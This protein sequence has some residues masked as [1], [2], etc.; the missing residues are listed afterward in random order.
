MTATFGENPWDVDDDL[1]EKEKR[2][3]RSNA[4]GEVD[5]AVTD[6]NGFFGDQ[7][8]GF[9]ADVK[10]GR[11]LATN[12]LFLK[13]VNDGENVP[14]RG[15]EREAMRNHVSFQFFNGLGAESEESFNA[16]IVKRTTEIND[17]R[18][19]YK[20]LQQ[21]AWKSAV[22]SEADPDKPNPF[23]WE[24]FHEKAKSMPGYKPDDVVDLRIAWNES[25]QELRQRVEPFREELSQ[26]WGAMKQGGKGTLSEILKEGIG[27]DL[28]NP[29]ET[30][31]RAGVE[32]KKEDT[33]ATAY[34]IYSGLSDD[35][36]PMFL[37]AL[38]VVAQTFP[39]EE[40]EG[41]FNN[42]V[43]QGGRG[44]DDFADNAGSI[45]GRGDDVSTL[46]D[47][48]GGVGPTGAQL[49]R[50]IQAERAEILKKKDFVDEVKRIERGDFSPVKYLSDEDSGFR[51]IEEGLYQAP[52]AFFTS[53]VFATPMIGQALALSSIEGSSYSVIRDNLL[54]SGVDPER[55][56]ILAGD[57][58]PL[59]AIPQGIMEKF[60]ANAIVGKMPFF[61]AAM[62]R[63]GDQVSNLAVRGAVR[64]GVGAGQEALLEV[65]QD[66]VNFAVQDIAS[67]LSMDV[68]DVVWMDG[69]NGVLDGFW[70]D[71]ATNFVTMLPLAIFGAAG[72]V[73][74]DRRVKA[75]KDATDTQLMALG[76]R[77]EDVA[78]FRASGGID[79]GNAAIDKMFV[80]LDPQSET[81]KAATEAMLSEQEAARKAAALA[82]DSGVFPTIT[83]SA[84]GW[85]VTDRTTGTQY[86]PVSSV[87]QAVKLAKE[88]FSAVQNATANQMDYLR[89]MLES[90]DAASKL[91]RPGSQTDTV[92][93]LGL[94]MTPAIMQAASPQAAE[95]LRLQIE[96]ME[97]AGE[98]TPGLARI[99]Y[100]MS[101]TDANRMQRQTVNKLFQGASVATVF[102]EYFHGIRREALAQNRITPEEE[103]EFL[104][105]MDAEFKRSKNKRGLALGLFPE[106]VTRDQVTEK[107]RD[108][109]ISK[110]AEAEVLKS[111]RGGR[112]RDTEK[113][114]SVLNIPAGVV[115]RNIRSLVRGGMK[116]AKKFSDL[117]NA[118]RGYFG[119]AMGRAVVLRQLERKGSPSAG[120]YQ[121]YLSKLTGLTEQ[122]MVDRKASEVSQ[123]ITGEASFDVGELDNKKTLLNFSQKWESKGVKNDLSTKNGNIILSRVV[124]PESDRGSGKGTSF[125]EDLTR[126]ADSLEL[127]ISATPST[128]FGGSS[129][130]RLKDFYKRFGFKENKGKS[131]DFSINESMLRKPND[132]SFSVGDEIIDPLIS[133]SV[134]RIKD[135]KQQAAAFQ[136][137]VR[138]FQRLREVVANRGVAFG[139]EQFSVEDR[140]AAFTEI[141][142]Q[143]AIAQEEFDSFLASEAESEIS[144]GDPLRQKY[145]DEISRINSE[146]ISAI[147]DEREAILGRQGPSSSN[148]RRLYSEAVRQSD[149][150]VKARFEVQ[151]QKARRAFEKEVAKESVQA[152]RKL[153]TQSKKLDRRMAELNEREI[154]LAS[155]IDLA[156]QR[157]GIIDALATFDG[158]LSALP[159][160]LRGRIGG[161]T[162]LA[163][164]T[165][166]AARLKFLE[167]RLEKAETVI[168]S[169]LKKEYGRLFDKL[170]ERSKP[171]DKAGKKPTG[172]LGGDVH[173]LF[174]TVE[175]AMTWDADRAD[176]YALSLEAQ[177]GTGNLEPEQE[178]HVALEAQMVRMVADW[179]NTNAADR[180]SALE[181]GTSI[182]ETA[183][184]RFKLATLMRAEDRKIRINNLKKDTGKEGTPGERD[185]K[186]LADNSL[187]GGWKDSLLSLISFEQT[188]EYIFGRGS[189]DAVEMVDAERKAANQYEDRYQDKA[190]GLQ[191]FYA[192][193]GGSSLAGEKIQYRML[194]KNIKV[195]DRTLSEEEIVDALMMYRQ[196][197][198]RRHFEG[199]KD[200]NGNPSGPWHYG[201]D[202]I[203]E[204]ES[205]LTADGRAL[206]AFLSDQYAAEWSYINPLYEEINGVNLP[207][208]ALYSPISVAPQQAQA[209]EII[210]PITGNASSALS[211]TPSWAK[212]RGNSI[213]EPKFIGASQKYLAHTKQ[214]EQWM[215]YAKFIRDYASPI[216]DRELGN[217]IAEKGGEKALT[218]IRLWM[219]HFQQGGNRDAGAQLALNQM[220]TRIAGRA[221]STALIGR[222]G[223]LAIQATQIGAAAAEMPLSSYLYRLGKLTSGQLD[224]T[225]ALK[226][227]FIQRRIKQLPPAVRAAMEGLKGTNPNALKYAQRKM[228]EVIGGVDG[229]VTAGTFA[230]IYDYQLKQ[231]EQL[232][233]TGEEA[234]QWARNEAERSTERIAQPTRSGTRSLFE[235]T[236]GG[237]AL[238]IVY[239]FASEARQKLALSA[240]RIASSDRSLGEKARAVAVTWVVGGLFASM[241]RAAVRD[242]KEDDDEEKTDP[243][244]AKRL[245]LS[246]LTGPLQG[247]P[248]LGEEIESSIWKTSGEYMP[249]GTLLGAIPNAF[250]AATRVVDWGDSK[251]DEI[252]RDVDQI[253]QGLGL[254]N[255]EVAAASSL[256]HLARDLYS[257]GENAVD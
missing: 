2:Q 226:S 134:D 59:A 125:M 130:S 96:A 122:D 100:G 240:W 58:A 9:G 178:A 137:I 55:A 248:F 112:N 74:A 90:V 195:G 233:Y 209:G 193:L 251:P 89:S 115:T 114:D 179:K 175:E 223:V 104:M 87:D 194:Q 213:A 27:G 61:D 187:K 221:A 20:E 204:A 50:S 102:H 181:T 10:Q 237:P 116:S 188:A 169:Y 141:E 66:Y 230:I 160:D 182:F 164:L 25:T 207:Y 218:S 196:E 225:E 71:Y 82:Q 69:E 76:A 67:A 97:K 103:L 15:P 243:W 40:Q 145:E 231:A 184:A 153:A 139:R 54:K 151:R 165:T 8:L 121:E 142:N 166:N 128:D 92:V 256:M 220:M 4:F 106:G 21:E 32:M 99:V 163:S 171:K 219:D 123:E 203:A 234:K 101:Q 228:G 49:R 14:V 23:T 185:R 35:E 110:L 111:R 38:G 170:L 143:R 85:T 155:R 43:K 120:K 214:I 138:E 57:M 11:M 250:T 144:E 174:R 241:I 216:R 46:G 51:I 150:K 190:E 42:L 215:S 246:A 77:P 5:R 158:I 229:L 180:S 208:N 189:K 44:V 18:N 227:D 257:L 156:D 152:S 167:G 16:Q 22:V 249:S 62:K 244:D 95:D 253:L 247:I 72:G 199:R 41:F 211:S 245:F 177:I 1:L 105:A 149:A 86:G 197:D 148:D 36:K 94:R 34:R 236:G 19:Q 53:A 6:P 172:K 252:M 109:A 242:I 3:W 17:R 168:E 60:Q 254:F 88:N 183:Y 63:I 45:P 162:Q 232:G 146:E 136:R 212:S 33:A 118:V 84:A 255:D 161:F 107:M 39:K 200:E 126:L 147:E 217:S 176:T 73:S 26:V 224:Y 127:T 81:A 98:L 131:K 70:K 56:R 29:T 159:P 238:R 65:G 52:G 129:V 12:D 83:Q 68:P 192:T 222:M 206:M 64:T 48:I 202:W 24:A 198:G 80:N 119:L 47:I 28:S 132:P 173:D 30:I 124:I 210:D 186:M 13:A 31:I 91:D 113:R 75:F 7:D 78:E 79:T 205:K 154:R 93:D 157:Q 191:N 239:S 201:A 135:P 37:D 133:N 235:N 140:N 108:E 117:F